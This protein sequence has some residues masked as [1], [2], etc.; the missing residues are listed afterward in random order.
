MYGLGIAVPLPA[1][2]KKRVE[3]VMDDMQISDKS[4]RLIKPFTVFGYDMFHAG[5]TQTTT[6]A[7]IGIP[8][9]FGYDSTS[10]VDRAH[11]LVNLD[12][13]SWGSEAGK[14]L[15]SAMVL[16]EEAQKFAIG[17]E[18]AYAQTLYVYMNSAFPAIVII[19]M[20]AFTTNCN[21]RL[22]LFGKPF[23]LRAILYSLVGLFGFGSWAFM[24]DF[25]TVHYETQV[26]KEMCALGESYI[27][28]GIEFYSKL[29]KRNIALRKLMG[30]KGEKLYT[31]TGNDQ[32]MMRQLHQ[33]LTLRKEYCELQLQE[34]KKQHKHSSTKVTSEDK[35]TISHNADTTAASP[36]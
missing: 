15:L 8:S 4:R 24:K 5:C 13:V 31:A 14:D 32:Y 28:G 3:D 35:L 25:T 21:N 29:L 18:I 12:Q 23:A 2:V 22:G 19:S 9:N 26:D 30:K 11:V 10:D 17:R 16:S 33:P 7:I 6:G 34:F 27:K 36:S 1:R 20:Y